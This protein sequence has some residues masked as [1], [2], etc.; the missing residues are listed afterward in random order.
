M[1][2][3]ET[4]GGRADERLYRHIDLITAA[5]VAV[6]LISNIASTK[7]LVIGPLTFDG[8]TILFPLA[9]IFGDVLTEVYGYRRARRVIWTGFFWITVAVLVFAIVDAL[10]PA[11]GW[12]LQES[13]S[14]ILGQTPR[15]V[16]GSLIAYFAGE[17]SNSYILARLKIVT[18]GRWLWTRTIGS[19]LVGQA[20]DTALF[21]VVA[22]W[23]VLPP[24]LLLTVFISNYVFKVGIE[25]LFTPITYAVVNFLKR[26]EGEDYFDH[27]T[28]FNP[29][30][31]GG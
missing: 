17:F 1:K 18:R 25:A 19:T 31:L 15:I 22:F 24:E 11:E 14:A 10:P 12:E 26:A 2:R 9:Y 7:I 27:D 4:A 20:V 28:D 16:L 8:G 21:L 6:L 3:S 23:G 13:F 29:F 30:A 5:F